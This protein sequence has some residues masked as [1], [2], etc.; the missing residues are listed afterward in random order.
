[1]DT[2]DCTTY[3]TKLCGGKS[4]N[5]SPGI[6]TYVKERNTSANGLTSCS[7]LSPGSPSG[8]YKMTLTPGGS[9]FVY[10]DMTTAGGPWAEENLSS[11][12]RK[13]SDTPK[14]SKTLGLDVIHRL[15]QA[16]SILRIEMMSWYNDSKYAQYWDFSVGDETSNYQLSVSGFSGNVSI[17]AMETHNGHPFSTYDNDNDS[18]AESCPVN[19]HGA[20]WYTQCHLC[21]LNGPH[22]HDN[23]DTPKSM[24]WLKFYS[25]RGFVP[26]MKS[27][28]LVK[29]LC[30]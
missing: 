25:D 30:G 23:G 15:T 27:R 14:Y 20:W 26:L 8:V 13:D 18:A 5:Q 1:M 3:T 2:Q 17:D 12:D 4:V 6:L 22:V 21:N 28:M 29:R 9:D 24:T 16:D 19:D 7:D 10:C 11:V